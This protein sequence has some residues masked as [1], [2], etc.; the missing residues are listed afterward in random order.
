MTKTLLHLFSNKA[1]T[2]RSV[3]E[4]LHE[5]LVA[6][7][8]ERSDSTPISNA[9]SEEPD[10]SDLPVHNDFDSNN[11]HDNMDSVIAI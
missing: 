11:Q 9:N 6:E 3:L 4:R 5:T 7:M 8:A 10:V 1:Q 2:Q